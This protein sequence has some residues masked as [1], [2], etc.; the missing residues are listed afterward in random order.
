M[1]AMNETTADTTTGPTSSEP[2]EKDKEFA[3]SRYLAA[4]TRHQDALIQITDLVDEI[5][6]SLL[7]RVKRDVESHVSPSPAMA[8][9]HE[10]LSAESLRPR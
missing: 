10:F 6:L 5:T 3:H 1:N 7:Q 9:Y 4:C 2:N 8:A